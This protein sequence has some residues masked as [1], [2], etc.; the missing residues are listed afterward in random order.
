MHIEDRL[1]AID[2]L[3]RY[4][5]C[6]DEGD[7]DA[8]AACFTEDGVFTIEGAIGSVPAVMSGRAEIRRAMGERKAAT[9]SAQRRHIITNVILDEDGDGR[10]RAACYLLLGSTEDGTL[11][12]PVTGRYTDLLVRVEDRWLIQ[13]RLLRLDSGIA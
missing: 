2:L 11:R 3:H 10:I 12:L 8:M 6:Y 7:L 9:A 13:D 1:L 5:H 4:G